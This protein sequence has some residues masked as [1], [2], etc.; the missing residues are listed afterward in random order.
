MPCQTLA[1][2]TSWKFYLTDNE[3]KSK[4]VTVQKKMVMQLGLPMENASLFMHIIWEKNM[5][6]SYSQD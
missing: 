4:R 2:K 5:A 1:N 6:Y 3:A